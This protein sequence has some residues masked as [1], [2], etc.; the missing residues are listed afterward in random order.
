M[1]CF[2]PGFIV[3]ICA[4]LLSAGLAFAQT[5]RVNIVLMLSDDQSYPD[6]ETYGNPN[7]DTPSLDELARQGHLFTRAYVTAPQCV[8]S[9][10]SIATG[11]WPLSTG[12]M[13]FSAALDEDTTTVFDI[14]KRG[15]Y[16]VGMVGRG[17]HLNGTRVKDDGRLGPLGDTFSRRLDYL[18]VRPE[19]SADLVS[20]FLA[21]RPVDR[22]FFLQIGFSDPHRPSTATPFEPDPDTISLPPGV[23]DS[24]IVRRSL[25]SYYGE[26][27]RLDVTVGQIMDVLGDSELLDNT[28]IIF[29]G[30]NG[31]AVYRGKGTLY[32]KGIHV[33]LIVRL[34]GGDGGGDV[35]D[36]LVSGVDLMPTILDLAGAPTPEGLDGAS[37]LD[38]ANA[39][40]LDR[41]VFAVRGS[42][43]TGL[44]GKNA[45]AFDLGRAI[46]SGRYKLIYNAIP[47]YP[48]GQTDIPWKEEKALIEEIG[49]KRLRNE[50]GVYYGGARPM[51]ELFDLAEDPGELHNLFG[52][53]SHRNTRNRL[54]TELSAWMETENDFV[55][56]PYPGLVNK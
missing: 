20:E 35:H 31:A 1:R 27:N 53:E 6:L 22:P 16:F 10:A 14:L 47:R 41:A 48:Y 55:P 13:R 32:E 49:V 23:P 21:A 52:A 56:I 19:A 33:P 7:L 12:V 11:L 54:L 4:L 37:L 9:R 30:D 46:I 40:P 29:M 15:G 17:H 50:F 51:F 18:S 26:V 24:A 2:L 38:G 36:V 39:I 8:Q 5:S 28:A 44:A 3:G 25:S 34:A 42:H 45:I 43:G